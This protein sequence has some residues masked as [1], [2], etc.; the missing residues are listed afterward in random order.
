MTAAAIHVV[1][2]L[3]VSSFVCSLTSRS[4]WSAAGYNSNISTTKSYVC[5]TNDSHPFPLQ[6]DKNTETLVIEYL[7]HTG[8]K[9][10]K[11]MMDHYPKLQALTLQGNLTEIEE[12]AFLDAKNI[13]QLIITKTLLREFPDHA[14]G[15][16]TSLKILRLNYN[17]LL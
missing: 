10:T 9:L 16:A 1:V 5:T 8:F 2:I 12:E 6:L 11:D 17:T 3:A 15:N 4:V 13:K 14:F 7:G